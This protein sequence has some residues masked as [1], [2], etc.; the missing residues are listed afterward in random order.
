MVAAR[1]NDFY[2][3]GGFDDFAISKTTVRSKNIA[4]ARPRRRRIPST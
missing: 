3:I 1:F 4:R 2:N